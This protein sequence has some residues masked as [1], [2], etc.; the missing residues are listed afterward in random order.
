MDH[1]HNEHNYDA[2][3]EAALFANASTMQDATP[4]ESPEPR[5]ESPLFAPATVS[6]ERQQQQQRRRGGR[7]E[8]MDSET[9]AQIEQEMEEEV[10][11]STSLWSSRRSGTTPT[12]ATAANDSTSV[13]APLAEMGH[14]A[15]SFL[16]RQRFPCNCAVTGAVV[17]TER[18]AG[19]LWVYRRGKQATRMQQGWVVVH[20]RAA[21]RF[22]GQVVRDNGPQSSTGWYP[23]CRGDGAVATIYRKAR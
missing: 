2:Q 14:A 8:G 17:T 23:L 21:D 4:M 13:V 3:E 6:R 16:V 15:E 12:A 11:R 7:T 22:V 9:E 18:D 19:V 10:R 5:P 20:R 1:K